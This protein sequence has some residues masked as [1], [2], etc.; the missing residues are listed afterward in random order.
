MVVDWNQIIGLFIATLPAT[1]TAIAAMIASLRNSKKIDANTA[2]TAA[3][4]DEVK[5]VAETAKDEAAK[6]AGIATEAAKVALDVAK[7][8]DEKL[9]ALAV[10][11]NGQAVKNETAAYEKG[12]SIGLAQAE[13]LDRQIA[14]NTER[15][16]GMERQLLTQAERTTL[17][18]ERNEAN[19]KYL[20]EQ[21][22]ELKGLMIG[23]GQPVPAEITEHLDKEPM[24]VKMAPDAD[25][26]EVIVVDHKEAS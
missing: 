14:V 6:V 16:N 21:L 24:L 22:A 23:R 18:A 12:L 11:V 3:T 2:I 15:L 20:R 13:R 5:H 4:K 8:K 9:D 25:P 19:N 7:V 1:L 17:H 10:A 26:V